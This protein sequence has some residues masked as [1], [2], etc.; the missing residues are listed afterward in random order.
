VIDHRETYEECA[1]RYGNAIDFAERSTYNPTMTK[2]FGVALGYQ[3]AV[4]VYRQDLWR[5]VR[6]EPDSWANVLAGGRRIKLLNEK[7]VGFSLA[8]ETKCRMDPPGDHVL[9][10]IVEAG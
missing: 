8:P 6:M 7:P 4:I 10:R 2:Y 1:H 3:P 5:T 9:L